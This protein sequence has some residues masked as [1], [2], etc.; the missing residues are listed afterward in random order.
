MPT[1]GTLSL[2]EARANSVT[3]KRA[4]LLQEYVGFIQGVPPGRAEKLES[5]KGE[6]TRRSGAGLTQPRNCWG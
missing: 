2:G 5:G 6:T 3:G 1:F 4:A